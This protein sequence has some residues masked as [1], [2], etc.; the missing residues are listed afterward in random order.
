MNFEKLFGKSTF[1]TS[2][3]PAPAAG[4]RLRSRRLDWGF[5]PDQAPNGRES[6]L[7]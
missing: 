2:G 6:C 1:V 7:Q 5:A 3:P 4:D